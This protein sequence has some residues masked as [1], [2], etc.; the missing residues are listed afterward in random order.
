MYTPLYAEET[1]RKDIKILVVGNSILKNDPMP[2][3]GWNGDWG[4]AATTKNTDF[5]HIYRNLLKRTK[6]YYSVDVK[7][8]NISAWENNFD[9]DLNQYHNIDCSDYDI[10]IVRLGENVTDIPNYYSALGKMINYFKAEKTK[11]IITGIIW[12]NNEKEN[13]QKQVALDNKYN[14]ISF[15]DF[16]IDADNYSWGLFENSQVAAHPSNAGM[17]YIAKL[18]FK[19]TIKIEK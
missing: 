5:L 4:M 3:I 8:M 6:K 15:D 13:I 1:K 12:E 19:T 18:L 14:Y 2:E 7:F 16:R 10:I 9:F 11:V 17:L